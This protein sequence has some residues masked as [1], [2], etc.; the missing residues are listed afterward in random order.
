MSGGEKR[1]VSIIRSLALEPDLIVADEPF[2]SL[3]ASLRNE[4]LSLLLDE[5]PNISY[6]FILHDLD[7]ASYVC[8]IVAVMY[9]GYLVEIGQKHYIFSRNAVRH[10]YTDTLL[11]VQDLLGSYQTEEMEDSPVL[12]MPKKDDCAFRTIPKKGGCAF[13]NRC[14]LHRK[15]NVQQ[16]SKCDEVP[17]LKIIEGNHKIACH[18]RS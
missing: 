8:D 1:R 15:L 9:M 10:P 14:A 3:D 7:V 13:L 12:T 17:E 18:F 6:L 5:M 4:M 2:S 11:L 16:K